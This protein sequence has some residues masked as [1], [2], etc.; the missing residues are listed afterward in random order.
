[1]KIRGSSVATRAA[2]RFVNRNYPY[3]GKTWPEIRRA[4]KSDLDAAAVAARKLADTIEFAYSPV[5]S[6]FWKREMMSKFP[7]VE[8]DTDPVPAPRRVGSGL[9][10][11]TLNVIVAP[12]KGRSTVEVTDVT[13]KRQERLQTSISTEVR[14]MRPKQIWK[15]VFPGRG[16][17]YYRLTKYPECPDG[18]DYWKTKQMQVVVLESNR[19]GMA[20]TRDET[21]FLFEAPEV[22]SNWTLVGLVEVG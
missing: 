20:L 8:P 19:D 11:E 18:Q 13:D 16:A 9:T 6:Q 12:V 14:T 5:P 22:P 2:E 7:D 10:A 17:K 1:M 3:L 21:I 15:V 4:P